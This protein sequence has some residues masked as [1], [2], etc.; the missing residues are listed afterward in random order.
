MDGVGPGLGDEQIRGTQRLVFCWAHVRR[1][2]VE[3]EQVAPAC[4]QV[5]SRIG[6]L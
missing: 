1:E 3:A 6:Q 4:A 5:L 2:F